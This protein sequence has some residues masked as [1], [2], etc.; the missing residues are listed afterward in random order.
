[1][2]GFTPSHHRQ[3]HRQRHGQ[4]HGQHHRPHHRQHHYKH[5]GST[6]GSTTGNIAARAIPWLCGPHL[7]SNC[8]AL[9]Q[10]L[11]LVFIEHSHG[12]STSL[13][14][15]NAPHANRH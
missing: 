13:A 6:T 10:Y 9:P 7:E 8:P 3:H 1:M 15:R 4:H 12:C 5:S 2:G 11:R 14:A